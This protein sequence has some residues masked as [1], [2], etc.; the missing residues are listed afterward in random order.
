MTNHN[1]DGHELWHAAITGILI[2]A[3]AVGLF[4]ACAF[5][6]LAILAGRGWV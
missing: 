2:E 1:D 3:V 5:V 6:W 4:F